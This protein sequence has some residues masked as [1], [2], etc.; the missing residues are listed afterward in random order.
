MPTF[1]FAV[2]VF[3]SRYLPPFELVPSTSSTELLSPLLAPT[4]QV[5]PCE[6][7]EKRDEEERTS[8]A[9]K[10]PRTI[11]T[12]LVSRFIFFL[13]PGES[14]RTTSLCTTSTSRTPMALEFKPSLSQP[15]V[16][17]RATT[18][19]SLLDTKMFVLLLSAFVF[20]F[21]IPSDPLTG[22]DL[23]LSLSTDPPRPNRNAVLRIFPCCWSCGLRVRTVRSSLLLQIHHRS[24]S[25]TRRFYAVDEHSSFASFN[26]RVDLLPLA[27]FSFLQLQVALGPSPLQVDSPLIL[28]RLHSPSPFCF[29]SFDNP[30]T[31]PRRL[32]L[33][34]LFSGYYVFDSCYI[35]STSSSTGTSVYLGRPWAAYARVVFQYSSLGAHINPAHWSVWR[36]VT[37]SLLSLP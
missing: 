4:M 6:F 22:A 34:H 17:S 20:S 26:S 28:V 14:T 27:S 7:E 2:V 10:K 23:F 9:S 30:E 5:E 13:H 37:F 18:L 16:R 24:V 36:F 35:T 31:D 3:S 1:V 32:C 12:D 25:R 29:A 15:T 8:D 11:R 33:F 19:A 21:S